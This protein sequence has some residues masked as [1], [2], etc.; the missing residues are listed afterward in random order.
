MLIQIE[1]SFVPLEYL[2]EGIFADHE[3]LGY[4]KGVG[5]IIMNLS[6]IETETSKAFHGRIFFL[7][8]QRAA[9]VCKTSA[10]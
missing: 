5:H 4:L 10:L 9:S 1:D 8:P 6:I 2:R 7:I 3:A